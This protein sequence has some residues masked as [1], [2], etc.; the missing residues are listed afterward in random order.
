MC[1]CVADVAVY[2]SSWQCVKQS[3]VV[4]NMSRS[5]AALQCVAAYCSVLQCIAVCCSVLQCVEESHVVYD[6]RQCV[7]VLQCCAVCCSALQCVKRSHVVYN[8]SQCVAVLQCVA[9]YAVC[10]GILRCVAVCESISCGDTL[11]GSSRLRCNCIFSC[12]CNTL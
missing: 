6:M 8:M 5:V 9:A 7:V 10:C 11:G 4:Y 1:C 3:H 2:C 12:N